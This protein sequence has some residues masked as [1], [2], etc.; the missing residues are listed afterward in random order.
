MPKIV[1]TVIFNHIAREIR[2]KW[3]TA[4]DKASLSACQAI[5]TEALPAL[6]AEGRSVKR[7]V[8]GG[9]LDFKIITTSDEASFATFESGGF[10]GEAGIVE[11]LKNV[12]GVD[13]VETQTYTIEEM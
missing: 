8:C 10:G 13:T 5:L 11:K 4:N 12:E 2:C 6:K 1:P 9:C 3:S 7:I